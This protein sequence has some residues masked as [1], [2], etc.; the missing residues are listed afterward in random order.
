V[1]GHAF[2]DGAEL[3]KA[4]DPLHVAGQQQ[5]LDHVQNQQRLHPME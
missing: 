2:D 4:G 5:L 3:F 1:P